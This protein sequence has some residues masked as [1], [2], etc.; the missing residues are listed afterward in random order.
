MKI[1]QNTFRDALK[2]GVDHVVDGVSAGAPHAE[3]DDARLEFGRARRGKC[4]CHETP[5]VL[6]Q[7]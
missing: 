4:N 3:D 7:A 2:A 1:P 5:R 6:R